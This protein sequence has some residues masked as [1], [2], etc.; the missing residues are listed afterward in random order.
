MITVPAVAAAVVTVPSF[1]AGRWLIRRNRR[2]RL[3]STPLPRE[4]LEI[5]ERNIA[6]YRHIPDSLKEELHGHL[7]ILIHEKNFEGCGGLEL[8]EEMKV[9]IAAEAS[10]LLLNRKATYFPRVDSILVYPH[11]YVAEKPS[12]IGYNM[13]DSSVRLGESWTQGVVV[14]AWDNVKQTAAT[15]GSGHNV[16]LHEFAHQLDQEDGRGDGVPILE[17]WS[18]YKAW[19]QILGR[20][21]DEL[22]EKMKRH[23]KDV[24]DYYG[25]TNPAEFFAVATETFFTRS[26]EMKSMHSALYGELREFYKQ[27]P[28]EWM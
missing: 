9:T 26:K 20:E 5:I 8:T 23:A 17:H 25:A 21:Y 3:T 4:W 14:L 2:K 28:A 27:D 13:K 11:A 7:Q 10:I 1:L 18:S 16:V 24:L 15:M 19:G 22:R 12:E 6:I